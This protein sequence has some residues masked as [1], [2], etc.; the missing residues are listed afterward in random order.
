MHGSQIQL[1]YFI[2]KKPL[3]Y[4]FVTPQML[5]KSNSEF[6]VKQLINSRLKKR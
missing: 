5:L 1:D 3:Q 2:K 4:R 6:Q